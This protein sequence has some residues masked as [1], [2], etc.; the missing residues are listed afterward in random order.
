MQSDKELHISKLYSQTGSS[1]QWLN[2][3]LIIIW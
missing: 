1:L 3:F 2:I